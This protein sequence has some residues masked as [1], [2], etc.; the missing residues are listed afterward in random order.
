M[1]K[2]IFRDGSKFNFYKKGPQT[3]LSAIARAKKVSFP[4]LPG[5]IYPYVKANYRVTTSG[6]YTDFTVKW[7]IYIKGLGRTKMKHDVSTSILDAGYAPNVT[8]E[9]QMIGYMSQQIMKMS[10]DEIFSL[11]I[12]QRKKLALNHIRKTSQ[13]RCFKCL[14]PI[15]KKPDNKGFYSCQRNHRL[16]ITDKDVFLAKTFNDSLIEDMKKLNLDLGFLN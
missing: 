12:Q 13:L 6:K 1:M 8:T 15:S 10:I 9:G 16:Y 7:E 11:L 5:L 2:L 3:D 4:K 14:V